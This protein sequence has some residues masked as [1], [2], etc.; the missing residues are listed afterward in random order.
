MIKPN[1]IPFGLLFIQSN[2][3]PILPRK[4]FFF[5]RRFDFF[6]KYYAYEYDN[7]ERKKERKGENPTIDVS[8]MEISSY[9]NA[10]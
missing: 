8:N 10:E 4:C 2:M 1:M 3:I 7:K 9:L 6:Q 5:L